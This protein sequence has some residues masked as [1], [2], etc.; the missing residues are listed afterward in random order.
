VNSAF[1]DDLS[2][3]C[4]GTD[5][6]GLTNNLFLSGLG[7]GDIG[8]PLLLAT[9][10]FSVNG[11]GPTTIGVTA[12]NSADP[13]QGLYFLSGAENFSSSQPLTISAAAVPEPGMLLIPALGLAGLCLV[14]RKHSSVKQ[15]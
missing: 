7:A 4:V 6:V 9:L 8:D 3:C 12:D 15:R 10:H 1:F 11:A 13:N 2:G 5:V 14:R